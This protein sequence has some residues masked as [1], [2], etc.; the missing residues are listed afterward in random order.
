MAN[1]MLDIIQ[2]PAEKDHVLAIVSPALRL[3]GSILLVW[4]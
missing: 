3:R 2:S 4:T 1:E